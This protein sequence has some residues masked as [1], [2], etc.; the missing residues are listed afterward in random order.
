MAVTK[1]YQ[2]MW[3][4]GSYGLNPGEFKGFRWAEVSQTPA[5]R[6]VSWSL[7]AFQHRPEIVHRDRP[8]PRG[9][10]VLGDRVRSLLWYG[11][12]ASGA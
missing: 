10:T 8:T 6:K 9:Q 5:L 11:L 3:F 2:F 12:A 1:L 7:E 4:G